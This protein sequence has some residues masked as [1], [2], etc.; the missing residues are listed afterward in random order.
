MKKLKEY[1]EFISQQPSKNYELI[2]IEIEK[3]VDDYIKSAT[4]VDALPMEFDYQ[5]SEGLFGSVIGGL[6]GFALGKAVGNFLIKQLNLKEGSTL[7][8]LFSS[9]MFFTVAGYVIGRSKRL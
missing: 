2:D 4:L 5:L 8:S 1:E 9:R 6:T 7:Y 3:Y